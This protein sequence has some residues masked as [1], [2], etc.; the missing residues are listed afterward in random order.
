M[1]NAFGHQ[2]VQGHAIETTIDLVRKNNALHAPSV[3]GRKRPWEH[4][5]AVSAPNGRHGGIQSAMAQPRPGLPPPRLQASAIHAVPTRDEPKEG[6]PSPRLSQRRHLAPTPGPTQ[7]PLLSLSHPRYGLPQQ[8]ISNLQ[9]LGVH[10]I[11]PWQSSCLLGKG[12]LSGDTN[13]IYTAPTGGGKSLVADVLLL[14][15]VIEQPSKKALL[16]LPYVAL[17]QEKSKW[18]RKLVEGVSKNMGE[19]PAEGADVDPRLRWKTPHN[20][21]RVA[22]FFGGSKARA[23][24]ADIDIA[25]CTIEKVG[26]LFIR[27]S[28]C[29]S[30][31]PTGKHPGEHCDRRWEHR[32]LDNRGVGRAAHD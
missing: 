3:A 2:T 28:W 15:R 6:T 21:I 23:T 31:A 5:L 17:V 13:L 10:A 20:H 30:N 8:L 26:A 1:S 14:K 4:D 29:S 27:P 12:L 11:Y 16:V 18:L 32:R 7:D 19:W 22:G 9:S 24:W 25:V